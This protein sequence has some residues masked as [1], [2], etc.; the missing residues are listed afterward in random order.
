MRTGRSLQ[1]VASKK[2]RGGGNKSEFASRLPGPKCRFFYPFQG[3]L[4][5]DGTWRV[6][7]IPNG[8]GETS[9][10]TAEW[11]TGQCRNTEK[12]TLPLLLLQVSHHSPTL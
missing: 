12:G 4:S 7:S 1:G 9:P 8:K 2:K 5:S 10:G 6:K 11:G 3:V